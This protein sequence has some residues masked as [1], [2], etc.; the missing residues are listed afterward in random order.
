MPGRVVQYQVKLA[1]MNLFERDILPL[2]DILEICGFSESTFWRTRKLWRET[3]WVEKPKSHI[4]GRRRILHRDDL[5]YIMNLVKL[6]PDWFLDE[7]LT[8]LKH[9]R[10]ISVHFTTIFR[11]LERMGMSRK[12]L[13]KIAAERNENVRNDYLRRISEY[14]AEYLGFLD[15]TSKN[16]RTLS[17]GYGRAK[18]GHR[19][20]KKEKFV[21]GTRLTATGLLTVDGMMAN[22]VVEG[23]MK[24]A[25]YLEFIEYEVM[26]LTTPFPGPLSVLVMDNARIHHGEEILE[27]AERFGVRIEFLP[28]YS[29]DF[30]PIEE[31]F[32]KIKAFIR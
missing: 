25:D 1:V 4:R 29:P 28:L 30:N 20:R 14:P 17:R 10:F 3:G 8:L 32:S 18:K 26:P 9:N 21:R 19:A 2:K 13:K 22:T 16:D 24:R 23:S 6:R 31:V 15:E 11:E 7:L 27:L 12:K 5:D